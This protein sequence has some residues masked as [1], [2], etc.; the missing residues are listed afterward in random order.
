MGPKH[1]HPRG[2]CRATGSFWCLPLTSRKTW[3]TPPINMSI[4]LRLE[5]LSN[6]IEVR[7]GQSFFRVLQSIAG[8][9][10][11]ILSRT[12]A[13]TGAENNPFMELTEHW[14]RLDCFLIFVPPVPE[15]VKFCLSPFSYNSSAALSVMYDP[16][17]QGSNITLIFNFFAPFP[18]I[19]G[20]TINEIFSTW[21]VL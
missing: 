6:S 9:F 17:E 10:P 7:G 13:S 18:M 11:V 3:W 20:K 2:V 21:A 5:T 15:I 8:V 16:V 14:T 19:A 1:I 4:C 12:L